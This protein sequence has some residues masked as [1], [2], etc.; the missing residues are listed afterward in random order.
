[1]KSRVKYNQLKSERDKEKNIALETLLWVPF[2]LL[3]P[4]SLILYSTNCI[5]LSEIWNV[6]FVGHPIHIHPRFHAFSYSIQSVNT[7][8]IKCFAQPHEA[9]EVNS[10]PLAKLHIVAKRVSLISLYLKIILETYIY[11]VYDISDM[12]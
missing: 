7:Q 10:R 6:N 12:T 4:S 2:I 1:M 9:R 3:S 11:N 8:S 5:P